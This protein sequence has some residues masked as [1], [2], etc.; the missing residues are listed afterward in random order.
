VTH[1]YGGDYQSLGADKLIGGFNELPT[2]LGKLGF[3]TGS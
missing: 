3:T 1:G 2:A